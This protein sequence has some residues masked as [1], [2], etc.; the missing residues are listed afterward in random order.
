MRITS[1]LVITA[2]MLAFTLTTPLQ[3]K[4]D[5]H[6]G[7]GHQNGHH[8]KPYPAD[9]QTDRIDI[10]EQ[11]IR[12]I[13][14]DNRELAGPA[15][16]LPPGIRNNLSRGKPLP[17]GIAKQLDPRLTRNLPQ[18]SGYDWRRTGEDA[19]L[20]NVTTGI[21]QAIINNAFD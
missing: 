16:N 6:P 9:G 19:V 8:S 2:S 15:D 18:Y 5:N 14:R 1:S 4:P 7:K 17:P 11:L 12:S 10:D 21:V 13:F 20:V 3:A